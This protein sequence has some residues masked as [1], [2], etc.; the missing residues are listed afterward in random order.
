MVF[1]IFFSMWFFEFNIIGLGTAMI[2]SAL[3]GGASSAYGASKA[4]KGQESAN[5]MNWNMARENRDWQE[6][7]SSTAHQ[8]E[9]VDLE[10][11]GL[12]RILGY[13][14]GGGAST[15]SGNVATAQSTDA[16]SSAIYAS[17]AKSM[18]DVAMNYAKMEEI[19]KDIDIKKPKAGFNK[20]ASDKV[21]GLYSSAAGADGWVSK[22]WKQ[23]KQAGSMLKP[24]WTQEQL[25]NA[26]HS[27]LNRQ[28]F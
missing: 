5:E 11:A 19:K 3:I 26:K 15:P 21:G 14:K 17:T 9:T 20:W 4:S 25:D 24:N 2:A 7:M 28:Q 1:R 13:S 23:V 12:N 6:R 16:V 27:S 10:A 22:A 18:S 8:R